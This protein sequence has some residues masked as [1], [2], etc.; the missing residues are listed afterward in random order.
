MKM[1]AVNVRGRVIQEPPLFQAF[2][3][4]PKMAW[5]WLVVRVWLGY[6]WVEAGLHKVTDPAWTLTGESLM[7]FWTRAVAIPAEGRPAISF[8]WYRSFIQFLLDTQSYVWFA[9]LV[10]FGEL[11]VG[12]ALIVGAV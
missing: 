2:F 6:Q 12:I 1:S 7:G 10:A 11:L 5:F 3:S 4:S 8:D 9:K